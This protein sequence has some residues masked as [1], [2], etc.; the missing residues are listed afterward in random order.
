[1]HGCSVTDC[2]SGS[3]EEGIAC[4]R[5]IRELT[6]PGDEGGK[7]RGKSTAVWGSVASLVCG[8]SSIA[9]YRLEQ[10]QGAVGTSTAPQKTPRCYDFDAVPVPIGRLCT[11]TMPAKRTRSL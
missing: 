11:S 10:R 1:M 9:R 8:T 2:Q 4:S 7:Q 3:I 6:W 5:S